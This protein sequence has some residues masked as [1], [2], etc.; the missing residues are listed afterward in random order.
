MFF[1][2]ERERLGICEAYL[3]CIFSSV[4]VMK[5]SSAKYKKNCNYHLGAL[6]CVPHWDDLE[7]LLKMHIPGFHLRLLE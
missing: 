7:C 6:K 5:A 2:S 1:S 3:T 4:F